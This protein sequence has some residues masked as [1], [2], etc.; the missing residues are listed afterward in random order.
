MTTRGFPERRKQMQKL[1]DQ[2]SGGDGSATGTRCWP[3]LGNEYGLVITLDDTK[4]ISFPVRDTPL[5]LPEPGIMLV[6][7]VKD[8][9]IFNRVDEIL[10]G[11]KQVI[12]TDKDGVKMRTMPVPVPFLSVAALRGA[13]RGLSVRGQQRCVD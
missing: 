2:F 10:K 13:Q 1:P 12:R 7:K 11:N 5:D 4:K 6:I 3:R 8:D 9:M